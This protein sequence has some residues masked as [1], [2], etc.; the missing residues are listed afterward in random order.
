MSFAGYAVTLTIAAA[1]T[2]AWV[3]SL[4]W[5]TGGDYPADRLGTWTPEM[6]EAFRAA[7]RAEAEKGGRP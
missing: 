5:M 1:A 6:T 7:L 2:F 4:L 3:G